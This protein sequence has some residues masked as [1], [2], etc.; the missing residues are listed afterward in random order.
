VVG[1]LIVTRNDEIDVMPPLCQS[2]AELHRIVKQ[3]SVRCGLDYSKSHWAVLQRFARSASNNRR[4][5]PTASPTM[6]QPWRRFAP[7]EFMP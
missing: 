4:T 7:S 3:P 6:D 2:V 1:E 5:E